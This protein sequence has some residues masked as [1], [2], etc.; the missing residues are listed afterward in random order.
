MENSSFNLFDTR[1]LHTH[2][3]HISFAWFI[4]PLLPPL[5]ALENTRNAKKGINIDQK[6][7]KG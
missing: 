7:K 3:I 6:M 1:S 2:T 5:L 4:L